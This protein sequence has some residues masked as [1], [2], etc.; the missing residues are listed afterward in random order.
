MGLLSR[1]FGEADKAAREGRT[2]RLAD[3]TREQTRK[4]LIAMAVRDTLKKHGIPPTCITAEAR[5]GMVAGRPRGVHLQLVFRE[6]QPELL[7]YVVAIESTVRARLLRLDPLSQAWVTGVSWRFEP[8]DARQWPQLPAA[9]QASPAPASAAKG[10]STSSKDTLEKLL[11][12]GEGLFGGRAGKRE[13]FSPTV[14]MPL[15]TR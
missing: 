9:S 4:E 5:P 10:A 3:A 6:W 2:S 14:P 7:A 15:P 8:T 12:S 13:D 11:G 1:I